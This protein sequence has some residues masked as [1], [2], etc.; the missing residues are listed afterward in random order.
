MRCGSASRSPG[1]RPKNLRSPDSRRRRRAWR[2]LTAVVAATS[3]S[4]ETRP[5]GARVRL[6]GRDVGV[7]PITLS[8]VTRRVA[9]RRTPPAG[10]Q[11]L[12]HD[13]DRCGGAARSASPHHSR[14]TLHGE[15]RSGSGRWHL[16]P[17]HGRRRGGVCV[18]RSRVQ[19]RADG[20]PGNPDRSV[21]RRADRHDDL[22]RNR[23][24]R[25]GRR[26]RRVARAAGGRLRHAQRVARRQQLARERHAAR[27]PGR[28]RHRR[29]RRHRH[30]GADAPAAVGRRDARRDRDRRPRPAGAGRAGAAGAVDGGRGPGEGRDLRRAVRLAAAG[31]GRAGRAGYDLEPGAAW[32]RAA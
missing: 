6:D 7:T 5:P 18:R 19:H 25:R 9:P 29:D 21:L 14:G 4:V 15:G 28:A 31:H 12:V 22:P 30:A 16:V 11:G 10:L 3:V 17:G 20:I 27:L 24:L 13:G 26:R 32:A 2:S 8:P 1:V 23:Q